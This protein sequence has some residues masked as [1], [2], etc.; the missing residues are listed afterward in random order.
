LVL[1]DDTR[2]AGELDNRLNAPFRGNGLPETS[3]LNYLKAIVLSVDWEINDETMNDLVQE[4]ERLK[5]IYANDR[6]LRL[7]FQ[8]LGSVGKYIRANKVRA[9][10]DSIRLL[11]S[12]YCSL[13]KAIFSKGMSEK[14]RNQIVLVEVKKFRELKEQI[15]SKK[16]HTIEEKEG[17]APKKK[18][19]TLEI[20][21]AKAIRK[22]MQSTENSREQ[23]SASD[24][25]HLPPHEALAFAVEEIKDVIRMEFKSLR[26]ELKLWREGR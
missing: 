17:S 8:L 1:N 24:R 3:P 12:V 2:I 10:P 14:E 21:N 5:R 23:S 25:G 26:S 11:N 18:T 20:L 16:N 7:F 13:E 4:T 19:P 22:E 6:A 15:G 9:H